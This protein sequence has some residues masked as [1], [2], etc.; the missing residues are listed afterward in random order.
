MSEFK[1][2]CLCGAVRYECSAEPVFSGN[3]HCRDCQLISGSGYVSTFFVPESSVTI[4]GEVKYYDKNGDSGHP[5]S[6]GFCPT[7]G[8]QVFGKPG[9]LA[10]VLG[11]RAGSLD[12]PELYHP[13]MDIYTA[14]AQPWDFMNPDLPK[15]PQLPPK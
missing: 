12:N 13:T 10:G 11:I 6:R 8:S 14:S 7:C 1:G 5:V 3:C 4:T 9:I 2:G 15:F